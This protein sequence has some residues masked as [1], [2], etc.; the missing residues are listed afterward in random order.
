VFQR[1]GR[2]PTASL[3]FVTTHD[4]FT[5][6]DLVSYERKHNEANLEDNRDGSND[7]R[8]W[9]AGAEREKQKRNLLATLLF[10][11]G[12]PLLLAGD[13]MGRT[14]QGN[15]NAYC[16]DSE[17]SWI[18]WGLDG[19]AR[20]LLEFTRRLIALRRAH[21]LFRRR[22]W[23]RGRAETAPDVV[24]LNYEGAE[25]TDQEWSRSS[26]RCL[27]ALISGRGLGERDERGLP[28]VDSD[29]L[30][31]LNANEGEVAFP[32][33][34]GRWEGLVDTALEA[35]QFEKIYPLRGRSLALL[36][37]PSSTDPSRTDA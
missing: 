36:A 22:T 29:L 30:L 9:D 21:P 1:S 11:Q 37:R 31:L 25:M 17:L 26:A 13:E 10:S 28:V 33:P 12:V 4:G 5:L 20:A 32:L 23:F 2:G 19:E 18:D 14:Q 27:G 3:N 16:H 8:S 34:S 7:N 6:H 15:N 35:P 24:W